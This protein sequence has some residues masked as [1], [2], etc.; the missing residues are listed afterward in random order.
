MTVGTV[1]AKIL[2]MQVR[3]RELVEGLMDENRKASVNLQ[4]EDLEVLFAPIG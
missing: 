3:K 1:E 2:E 4:P